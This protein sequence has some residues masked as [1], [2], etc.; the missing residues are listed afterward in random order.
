MNLKPPHSVLFIRL[1]LLGDIIMT[2]PALLRFR[3]V[4]PDAAVYYA[5]EEPF[6]QL[7]DLLPVVDECFV[8]P[9]N[10]SLKDYRQ[11]RKRIKE[12]KIDT[13]IDFHSGPKSALLTRLSGC[14]S[15]IGYRTKN[16][17]WAYTQ[18]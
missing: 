12:K 6:A 16:R 8:I 15:R 9:R 10:F 2:I 18:L 4:Y 7:A 3:Q 5:L 13:V 11:W 1:R 14:P 17:N